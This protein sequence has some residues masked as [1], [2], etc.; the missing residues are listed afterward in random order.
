MAVHDTEPA[1]RH[2]SAARPLSWQ[3]ARRTAWSSD[4]AG[5]PVRIVVR[6]VVVT[7][8]AYAAA[9]VLAA[10]LWVQLADPPAFHVFPDAVLMDEEEAGRQFGVDL[11]YAGI[12]G[13]LAVPLG[14]V[15]GWRWHR[16]GWPQVIAVAGGAS[17]A[18]AIAWR[19]GIVWGPDDPEEMVP[20]AQV[21]D[22]IPERLDVH[23][24][25][26]LF[27]WP[28]AALIGLIAAVLLFSRPSRPLPYHARVGDA[29]PWRAPSDPDLG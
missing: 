23:A 25:G 2:S 4:L 19:L 21:G 28:V 14:F 1:G 24:D 13:A 5:P 18:A 11:M 12:A 22:E 26:L 9:G 10:W 8:L 16:I 17:I 27:T 7:C 3:Q 29:A 15:T 20:L 6:A